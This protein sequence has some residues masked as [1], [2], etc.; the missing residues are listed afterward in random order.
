MNKEL[1][2]VLKT[3]KKK[4]VSHLEE[5]MAR[6]LD[7]CILGRPTREALFDP[8]GRKWRFDF[9][10]QEHKLAIEVEGG[11]W[12]NG[13]HGRGKHYQSDTEKYNKAAVLGIHVLRYT[14]DTMNRVSEDI[15]QL[16]NRRYSK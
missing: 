4:R 16:I 1:E 12:V 7:C 8:D 14:G 3:A 10:W 2:K 11:T 6:R 13:A 9:Y 15:Q 5:A